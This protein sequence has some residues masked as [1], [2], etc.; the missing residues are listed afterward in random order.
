M[1]DIGNPFPS[2]FIVVYLE[3]TEKEENDNDYDDERKRK[4]PFRKC[5][6]YYLSTDFHILFCFIYSHT[7]CIHHFEEAYKAS[8]PLINACFQVSL[9]YSYNCC[10]VLN[11]WNSVWFALLMYNLFLSLR[12]SKKKC[13]EKSGKSIAFQA[14]E[15]ICSDWQK[16]QKN[17]NH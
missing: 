17:L 13:F 11:R 14:F 4:L 16:S 12:Y 3:N 8:H 6:I 2:S 7:F 10:N 9:T 15:K 1:H 5:I